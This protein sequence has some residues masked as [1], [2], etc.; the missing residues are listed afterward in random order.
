MNKT[1]TKLFSVHWYGRWWIIF[2]LYSV[3]QHDCTYDMVF[4]CKQFLHCGL[5]LSSYFGWFPLAILK[6]K[7]AKASSFACCQATLRLWQQYYL[8]ISSWTSQTDRQSHID[9]NCYIKYQC[10]LANQIKE[11]NLSYRSGSAGELLKSSRVLT[12]VTCSVKRLLTRSPEE[13]GR[14]STRT[15]DGWQR[16]GWMSSRTSSTSSHLVSHTFAW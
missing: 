16:F 7:E 4:I 3:L 6:R 2:I 11:L 14:S 1:L 12:W 8:P 15:T 9:S 13:P 5:N 10:C